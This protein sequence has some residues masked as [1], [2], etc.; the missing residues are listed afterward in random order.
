MSTE[1]PNTRRASSGPVSDRPS[2]ARPAVTRSF[3]LGDATGTLTV[4]GHGDGTLA[5]IGLRV[6][7]HGSTIAGLSEAVATA[8]SLA[9]QQGAPFAELAA[10]WQGMRFDPA[11]PTSDPDIRHAVSLPDYLARRLIHDFPA[12]PADAF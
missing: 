3:H 8:A 1:I 9:L 12:P 10:Q 5:E 2:S 11:G 4:A 7:K 6:G